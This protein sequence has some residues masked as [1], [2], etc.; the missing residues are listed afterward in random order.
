MCGRYVI[1]YTVEEILA[2]FSA[3]LSGLIPETWAGSYNCAPTQNLPLI[4][5]GADGAARL[6][7]VRWGLIPHWAGQEAL[8]ASPLINARLE[9]VEAKPSFREAFTRRP[10]LIP[11]QGFYEWQKTLLGPQP[12]FITRTDAQPLV[13]AGIWERWQGKDQAI[14]SFAILTTSALDDMS[15]LHTRAP[16][17]VLPEQYSTWLDAREDRS[18]ALSLP[19]AG[20][21]RF[22][23]V[24]N[25]VNDRRAQ[26]PD[27]IVERA[28]IMPTLNLDL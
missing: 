22:H 3:N 20:D 17:C 27:L 23:P 19:Q 4:R 14:D 21:F 10:A 24:S 7:F 15:A 2:Q 1:T 8:S 28:L 13:F 9:T 25:A 11:A 12:Y 26:G 6:S 5:R 18:G 16:V